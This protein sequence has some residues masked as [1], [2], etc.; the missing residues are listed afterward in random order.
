MANIRKGELVEPWNCERLGLDSSNPADLKLLQ[1]EVEDEFQRW[2]RVHRA[3]DRFVDIDLAQVA[4]DAW[5]LQAFLTSAGE[6]A[7]NALDQGYVFSRDAVAPD[8]GA[9]VAY[10]DDKLRRGIL[11]ERTWGP[12]TALAHKHEELRP[13][14]ARIVYMRMQGDMNKG[15][16]RPPVEAE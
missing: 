5:V 9:T 8:M 15:V 13:L 6:M 16:I 7:L 4:D 1:Q 3:N 11:G 12:I 14:R 2:K 10:Y